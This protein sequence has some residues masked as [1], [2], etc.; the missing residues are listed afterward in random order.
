MTR[1]CFQVMGSLRIARMSLRQFGS[2]MKKDNASPLGGPSC[3]KIFLIIVVRC[4]ALNKVEPTQISQIVQPAAQMSTSLWI[5]AHPSN[6]S[7]ARYQIVPHGDI[8][9]F[10]EPRKPQVSV[11]MA[12]HHTGSEV[13][14]NQMVLGRIKHDVVRLQVGV[15]DTQAMHVSDGRHEL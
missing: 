14:D 1:R 12:I 2:L 13:D 3:A 8:R 9:L 10:L 7:G 11:I 5:S 4:Q 6:V 15:D